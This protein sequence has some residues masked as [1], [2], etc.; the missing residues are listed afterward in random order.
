MLRRCLWLVYVPNLS[1]SLSVGL[2]LSL[3]AHIVMAG[4]Q[5][6]TPCLHCLK[7]AC[8]GSG[9]KPRMNQH[10][11]GCLL[12]DPNTR[13]SSWAIEDSGTTVSLCCCE[14]TKHFFSIKGNLNIF[15][16][17]V[18]YVILLERSLHSLFVWPKGKISK[19]LV[20]AARESLDRSFPLRGGRGR[21]K[22]ERVVSTRHLLQQTNT[23]HPC[24]KKD[25]GR[26]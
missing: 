4:T 14:D 3:F 11:S 18:K 9:K 16:S 26:R 5:S 17:F 23:E 22:S 15:I 10:Y 7:K 12:S 6:S 21:K 8:C 20:N 1:L 19:R 13:R 25:D 24:R 2:S